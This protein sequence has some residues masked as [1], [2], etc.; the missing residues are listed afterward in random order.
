MYYDVIHGEPGSYTGLIEWIKKELQSFYEGKRRLI[1]FANSLR[2]GDEIRKGTFPSIQVIPREDEFKRLSE[3]MMEHKTKIWIVAT[4]KGPRD[5]SFY[6][7]MDLA[8]EIYGHMMEVAPRLDYIHDKPVDGSVDYMWEGF[9]HTKN[10]NTEL[11][12]SMV[13]ITYRWRGP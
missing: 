10:R 9:R 8:G 3:N 6:S 11:S 2:E 7:S 5:Q 12:H 4:T 1:V 13:S